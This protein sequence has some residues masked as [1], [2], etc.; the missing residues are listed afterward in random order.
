MSEH[1]QLPDPINHLVEIVNR[2]DTESFLNFFIVD[3]VVNDS[4]RR[5]VGQDSIRQWSDRRT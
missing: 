5:F 3:G 1:Q 4:G 2:G